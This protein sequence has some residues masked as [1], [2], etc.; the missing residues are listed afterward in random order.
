MRSTTTSH[1]PIELFLNAVNSLWEPKQTTPYPSATSLLPHF[2][3]LL[4][5]PQ[6]SSQ[7]AQPNPQQTIPSNAICLSQ[8]QINANGD[9]QNSDKQF[10]AML[11]VC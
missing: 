10:M 9:Q 3:S 2:S 5:P 6:I 7:M 4:H 1:K 11:T 8:I